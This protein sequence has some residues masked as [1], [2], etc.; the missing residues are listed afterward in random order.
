MLYGAMNFPV[1]PVLDEL[2]NIAE[3]EFDYLELTMDSPQAHYRIIRKQKKKLL[4]ALDR[5]DMKILCHLPTFVSTAD[6]TP[7]LRKASLTEVLKS[8][9]VA[10]E[11]GCIKA[12]LH[13]AF[14]GYLGIMVM[15]KAKAYA[16]ESLAAIVERADQL[17]LM[18]CFENMFPRYH[19]MVKPEE[20]TEIFKLF[21][22][23]NMTLDIGHAHIED[24]TGG[25]ALDFIKKFP[26]RIRHVH[27][28]DNFGKEDDHLPI[29]AGTVN[30]PEVVK[31]L[32]NIGYD[33]TIT[34][35]VFSRDRD[36]LRI[37]REK[38]ANMFTR[39]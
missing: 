24:R 4:K 29:G 13:P 5:Y 28:S 9:D 6:L 8:L 16:L 11:I 35:E 30:F 32:K 3:L 19:S 2:K 36:Y 12:V 39:L 21:P 1:M 22:Q 25:R 15:D 37:S 10:A 27:V 17:G 7:S 38:L 33:D 23:L 34:F 26:N 31:A 14:I 20:F 18:V